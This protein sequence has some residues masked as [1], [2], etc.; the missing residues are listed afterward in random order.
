MQRCTKLIQQVG[1][2]HS[3]KKFRIKRVKKKYLQE[4]YLYDYFNTLKRLQF[5]FRKPLLKITLAVLKTN[6]I[7]L[8]K[9][10]ISRTNK[11]Q[12]GGILWPVKVV[13]Q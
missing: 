10:D 7:R 12:Q 8:L 4:D 5:K 6:F 1:V 2:Q 13:Y 3:K 9:S 11:L